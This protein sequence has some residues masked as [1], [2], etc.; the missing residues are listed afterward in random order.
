MLCNK[1]CM[2]WK[3]FHTLSKSDP[4]IL[5]PRKKGLCLSALGHFIWSRQCRTMY[6]QK[7]KWKTRQIFV[8]NLHLHMQQTPYPLAHPPSAIPFSAAHS[9]F[10]QHTPPLPPIYISLV[11][12]QMSFWKVRIRKFQKKIVFKS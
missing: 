4:P 6:V 10:V 12:V 5:Q 11:P 2:L 1:N 3:I 7:K 8:K 9:S